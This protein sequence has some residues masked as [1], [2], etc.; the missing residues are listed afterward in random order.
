M[1]ELLTDQ[2]DIASENEDA[3]RNEALRKVTQAANA[4]PP[5]DFDGESCVE[6]GLEIPKGRLALGKWTCI[7]CQTVRD[8]SKR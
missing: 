8:K 3:Y 7:F 5:K 4:K 2:A 1:K 6:C